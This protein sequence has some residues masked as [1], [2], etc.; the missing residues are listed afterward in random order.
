MNTIFQITNVKRLIYENLE[1][2]L[3]WLLY[4]HKV[5][6]LSSWWPPNMSSN[7]AKEPVWYS[8]CL[9]NMEL[10]IDTHIRADIIKNWS[11]WWIHENIMYSYQWIWYTERVSSVWQQFCGH[12]Q[13]CK[14]S[15]TKPWCS[16]WHWMLHGCLVD[17]LSLCWPI[18]YNIVCVPY[19]GP[20]PFT[21]MVYCCILMGLLWS[22]PSLS[23][24]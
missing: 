8:F 5:P 3:Y 22:R 21:P 12:W 7:M 13:P 11:I 1:R 23:S 19:P 2:S 16:L 18:Y 4:H 24:Y 6:N 15:I 20:L 14:L 10:S 9:S 17:K